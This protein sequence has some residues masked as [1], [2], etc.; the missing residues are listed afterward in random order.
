M[1]K[2]NAKYL[3]TLLAFVAKGDI[4]YY[5]Y[6]VRVEPHPEGGAIMAATNGHMMVLIRDIDAVCTEPAT[7]KIQADA[8]RFGGPTRTRRGKPSYSIRPH[9]VQYNEITHRMIITDGN[10]DEVFVQPGNASL[11]DVTY[12]DWRKVV[13]KFDNLKPG[14]SSMVNPALLKVICELALRA[15]WN[16]VRFWQTTTTEPIAVQLPDQPETLVILMP[17]RDT[18][19]SIP[20]TWATHFQK[21]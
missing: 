3:R 18:Q 10:G 5:L 20:D 1:I 17:M 8:V 2:F 6:G 13:P 19:A 11:S 14:L 15:K 12:P 4:R 16:G 7:V 21:N 9:H